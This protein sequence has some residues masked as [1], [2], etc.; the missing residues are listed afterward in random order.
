MHKKLMPQIKGFKKINP[1][2]HFIPIAIGRGK[3][4][5]TFKKKSSASN[6]FKIKGSN[7]IFS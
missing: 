2:N 3:K 7:F 1:F 4:I 6:A 5:L